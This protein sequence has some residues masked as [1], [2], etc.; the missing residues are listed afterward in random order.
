MQP[1]LS[2]MKDIQSFRLHN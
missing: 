2:P 1:S